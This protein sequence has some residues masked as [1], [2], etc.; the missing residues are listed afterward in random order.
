MNP[1]IAA[2]GRIIG[3]AVLTLLV[4]SV[5]IYGALY[6]SPGSPL[7]FL[8]GGHSLPPAQIKQVEAFYHLNES[9]LP[10]YWHWLMGILHGNFGDS[11]IVHQSVWSLIS[12][13]LGSTVFLLV[14][15]G[16]LVL[17]FGLGLGIIAAIRGGKADA[18]ITA[19]TS[20]AIATPSFVFALVLI[21]LFAVGTKWFPV[22]GSGSGVA[23]RLWHLTLPAIV[24][25]TT[26]LGYVTQLT[27]TAVRSELN[28]EHVDTARARGI[29]EHLVISRHVVRNAMIPI[30]TLTSVTLAVL[31]AGLAVVEDVF[32][33][34]GIG[35]YLVQAVSQHDFPV[36]Q[37]IC[38][39]LVAAFVI[40]SAIVDLLY[41][42]IDPRVRRSLNR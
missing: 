33:L 34:N 21:T 28:R 29:P 18:G 31:I 2:F 42:L 27:R 7:G 3:R 10:G 25:A 22:S 40:T 24:L 35:S 23:D 1:G 12:P 13:R 20:V 19:L 16:L 36:V 39:L 30:V 15:A 4:S 14:Y 41:P 9:F 38:L 26:S 5:V 17:L 8:T 32:G 6:L 11:V 37:A